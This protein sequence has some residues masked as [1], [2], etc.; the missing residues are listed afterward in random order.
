MPYL[1]R[2]AFS[3][4]LFLEYELADEPDRWPESSYR[5]RTWWSRC[6]LGGGEERQVSYRMTKAWTHKMQAIEFKRSSSNQNIT[7]LQQFQIWRC[8]SHAKVVDLRLVLFN[9]L[10]VFKVWLEIGEKQVRIRF[11]IRWLHLH[12]KSHKFHTKMKTIYS[13][14]TFWTQNLC[15]QTVQTMNSTKSSRFL[16]LTTHHL[17]VSSID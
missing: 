2:K 3:W 13:A 8:Q 14:D 11:Q 12:H 10:L 9:R 17:D 16:D 5:V 6:K 15:P 1:H 7:L 4:W